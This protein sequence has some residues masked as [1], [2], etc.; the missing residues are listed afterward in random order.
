VGGRVYSKATGLYNKHHKYSEQWNPCHPFQSVYDFQQA[1]SFSQQ[2]TTWIDQHLRHGLDIFKIEFFQ[3]AD[4]VQNLLSEFNFGLGDDSSIEDHA[5]IFG[6][7]YCRNIFR[8][9]QFRLAH[10]PFQAHL[11]LE[12]VLFVDSESHQMRSEMNRRDWWW[13]TQNLLPA[14]A[15][16]APVIGTSDK[17]H[18]TN[19]SGNQHTWPLY[20]T[21]GNIRR[22]IRCTPRTH[23][24]ILIRL[25][26]C[27]PK[28]TKDTDDALPSVVGTVLSH[29]GILT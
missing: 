3:S 9:I 20:L 16:I 24:W 4:I 25:I 11:G 17:P 29:S 22:D 23:T 5:P 18:L 28:G 1:Q 19:F 15:T 6:T 2:V 27:P 14:G 26:P 13:D 21:I 10:L 12:P 8:C 7:L